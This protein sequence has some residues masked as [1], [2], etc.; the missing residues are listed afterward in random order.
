MVNDQHT[1]RTDKW[2]FNTI[3]EVKALTIFCLVE[4][5]VENM[6]NEKNTLVKIH[7]N[8]Q[9]V[10]GILAENLKAIGLSLYR[11]E[12]TIKIIKLERKPKITIKHVHVKTRSESRELNLSRRKRIVLECEALIKLVR[13]SAKMMAQ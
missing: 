2:K 3:V 12:I 6:S 5:T 7:A 13:K 4:T 1:I 8:S 9:I 11:G 10:W